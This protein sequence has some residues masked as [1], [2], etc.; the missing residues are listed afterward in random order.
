MNEC[1]IR[2]ARNISCSSNCSSECCDML[3]VNA[4]KLKF[5]IVVL[6]DVLSYI[7]HSLS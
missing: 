4:F 3:K 1:G 7:D 5:D 2:K 6:S